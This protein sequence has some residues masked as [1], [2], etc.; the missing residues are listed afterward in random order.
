VNKV[1]FRLQWENFFFSKCVP[2]SIIRK[3]S[4]NEHFFSNWLIISWFA[5]RIAH[6]EK[7]NG[8][9]EKRTNL[10]KYFLTIFLSVY[11]WNVQ[12]FYKYIHKQILSYKGIQIFQ[13]IQIHCNPYMVGDW[14]AMNLFA[15][16]ALRYVK[17]TGHTQIEHA[18]HLQ[19]WQ[20]CV[21]Q[22]VVHFVSRCFHTWL[23]CYT[24]MRCELL[25]TP[26]V[27][28][29]AWNKCVKAGTPAVECVLC[30]TCKVASFEQNLWLNHSAFIWI[31]SWYHIES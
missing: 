29:L 31:Y 4:Q 24:S 25:L 26:L 23:I 2:F 17:K 5:K 13:E 19:V 20:L 1:Y 15:E 27:L 21:L 14:M 30:E 11:K 7:K 28:E 3:K 6:F 22:L 12:I 9:L 16:T 10:D 18:R 8:N